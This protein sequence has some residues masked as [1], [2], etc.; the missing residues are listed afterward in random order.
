M[1]LVGVESYTDTQP[2]AGPRTINYG[3]LYA[4]GTYTDTNKGISVFSGTV[5]DP[6]YIDLGGTFDTVN[7]RLL[8]GGPPHGTGVPGVLS[9]SEDAANENFASDTVSGFAVD[10]IALQVPID[11]LTS[12]GKVEPATSPNATIGVWASTSR[13]QITIRRAAIS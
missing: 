4:A 6:F 11:M 12:S 10:A 8:E 7:L 9:A 1:R 2:F 13:P 3:A 5:D